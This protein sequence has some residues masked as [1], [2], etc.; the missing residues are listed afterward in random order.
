[1]LLS[2]SGQT[3]DPLL[4]LPPQEHVV[5]DAQIVDQ[6]QVLVDGLDAVGA[7]LERRAEVTACRRDDRAAVGL[8][9]SA[10]DLDQR[11]FARA[12][13]ADQRQHFALMQLDADIDAAR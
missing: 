5:I 1:M 3:Q 9:E 8:V 2:S 4:V 6:R 11:R 10:E 12:I 7:G 13:V